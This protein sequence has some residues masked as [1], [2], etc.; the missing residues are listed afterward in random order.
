ML[1]M[2]DYL[3]RP[4]SPSAITQ[5]LLSLGLYDTSLKVSNYFTFRLQEEEYNLH[6]I[7][8]FKYNPFKALLCLPNLCHTQNCKTA[9]CFTNSVEIS[10]HRTGFTYTR[11]CRSVFQIAISRKL[12]HFQ[13]VLEVNVLYP[14]HKVQIA[15]APNKCILMPQRVMSL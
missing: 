10:I 6:I 13:Q 3:L 7:S 12:K 1:V 15:H 2:S 9:T 11:A 8:I 5:F 14:P 4:C